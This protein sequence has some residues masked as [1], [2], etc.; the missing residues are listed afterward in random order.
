MRKLEKPVY[1]VEPLDEYAAAAAALRSTPS[2]RG[3][4]SA[5]GRRSLYEYF[6]LVGLR[7]PKVA[8]EFLQ[9][10]R[11]LKNLQIECNW[12]WFLE[13]IPSLEVIP[14]HEDV[15]PCISNSLR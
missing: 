2:F 4:F 9:T 5:W 12:L 13:A 15:A 3:Y 1:R 14:P 7:D 8:T 11:K 10:V 6:A